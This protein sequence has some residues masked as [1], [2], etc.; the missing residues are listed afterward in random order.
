MAKRSNV[1]GTFQASITIRRD[2]AD[3]TLAPAEKQP[4]TVARLEEVIREALVKEGFP[5]HR[6]SAMRTD[7]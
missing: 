4:P 1:L 5:D 3:D 6:V 2:P 7:I